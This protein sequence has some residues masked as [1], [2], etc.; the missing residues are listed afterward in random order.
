[1]DCQMHFIYYHLARGAGL[2]LS[3]GVVAY[4]F[5]IDPS[6]RGSAYFLRGQT[7]R[8]RSSLLSLPRGFNGEEI[9]LNAIF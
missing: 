2:G 8:W 7:F 1:M 4:H 9:E 6:H 5:V 3:G